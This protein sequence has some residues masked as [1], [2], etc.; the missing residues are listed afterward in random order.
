MSQ[1]RKELARYLGKCLVG[2]ALV[3]GAAS[4]RHYSDSTWCLVSVLLVFSPLSNWASE[5]SH[6][7]E[8]QLA[9][10]RGGIDVFLVGDEAHA[11][12]LKFLQRVDQR[13]GRAG[14]AVVALDQWPWLK[15]WSKS[16]IWN[17]N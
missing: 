2:M 12:A 9:R 7:V 13:L 4:Y 8:N 3:F 5:A 10:G 11:Q 16:R 17:C 6:D 15:F 1:E 14:K